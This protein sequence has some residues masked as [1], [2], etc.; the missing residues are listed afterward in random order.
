[1]AFQ[2]GMRGHCGLDVDMAARA[3]DGDHEKT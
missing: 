1:M 2:Y 3:M